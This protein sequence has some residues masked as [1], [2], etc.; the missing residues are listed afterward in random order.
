MPS[1]TAPGRFVPDM[2]AGVGTNGTVPFCLGSAQGR[3]LWLKMLNEHIR[4]VVGL[5]LG[6]GWKHVGEALFWRLWRGG[7]SLAGS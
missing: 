2:W 3:R 5:L 6:K 7:A 4:I 1:R